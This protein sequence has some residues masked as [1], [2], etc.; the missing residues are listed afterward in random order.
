[1]DYTQIHGEIGSIR[2]VSKTRRSPYRQTYSDLLS[3][4]YGYKTKLNLPERLREAHTD[5]TEIALIKS[6][7]S[8]KFK[9]Y[10]I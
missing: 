7:S 3:K 5:Q 4:L 10:I 6:Y 9:M 1:M 8:K 2:S